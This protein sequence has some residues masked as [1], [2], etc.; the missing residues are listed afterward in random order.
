MADRSKKTLFKKPAEIERMRDAGRV[1]SLVLAVMQDAVAPGVSTAELDDL[2]RETIFKEGGHPSFLGHKSG[3]TLYHW[4]ICASIDQEV[5]HGIPRPDRRLS[6]GEIVSL[7]VGVKLN[8]WHADSAITVPVGEVSPQAA[9]LIAV[10]RES[11]WRGIEAVR[12]H[13]RL[14]AIGRAVQSYVEGCGLHVVKALTGHGIGRELWE[15]PEVLNYMDRERPNPPLQE[16][17]VLAIEPMVNLG[18]SDVEVLE[19][20]WTIVSK[21]G[22]LSA[23]FEHTIAVTRTGFDI[24][25]RGLHDPGPATARGKSPREARR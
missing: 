24:L 9:K 22:S 12:P 23:H 14:Q 11:L 5:V 4:S 21:D 7:D 18:S 3:E 10:T 19:D 17:M 16:G 8:G 6:E 2:A 20:K 13:A 15:G 1:V 25:T